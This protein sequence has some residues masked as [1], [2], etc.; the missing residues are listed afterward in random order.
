MAEEKRE[1]GNRNLII[2][3]SLLSFVVV[4]LVVVIM[5]LPIVKKLPITSLTDDNLAKECLLEDDES[6]ALDCLDKKASA[7]Y[8]EGDCGKALKVYDDIPVGVF[9]EYTLSDDYSEA[10]AL[11][12][13]CED[14]ELQQYWKNKFEELSSQLEGRS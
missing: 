14:E 4:V 13:R 12:L 9:D 5:V 1:N 11:S 2:V 8:D 6:L 3:L 7:Y 10:Y